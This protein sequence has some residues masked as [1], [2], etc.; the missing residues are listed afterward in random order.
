MPTREEMSNMVWQGVANG[1]NGII[2]YSYSGL[3]QN[4]KGA[5]FDKAWADACAF[6]FEVKKMEPV[7]L[8]DDLPLK[9]ADLPDGISV[10]A[11]RS[12]G[13]C[14]YLVVNGTRERMSASVP[15]PVRGA[16]FR[17]VLGRGVTLSADEMS[18]D[19]DFGPLEYAF[20]GVADSA[21]R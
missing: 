2:A 12:K 21:V 19:C 11:W 20:V 9:E 6:V 1:A 8:S 4:L 7:L 17:T 18:L 3:R 15:I 5:A 16:K 14:W 10:R 13:R